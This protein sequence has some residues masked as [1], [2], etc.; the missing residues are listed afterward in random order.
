MSKQK[1]EQSMT[2]VNSKF[3][4]KQD[5]SEAG[6]VSVVRQGAPNMVDPLEQAMLS[7]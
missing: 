6:S 1:R 5:L 3:F 7:H 4:K 2:K